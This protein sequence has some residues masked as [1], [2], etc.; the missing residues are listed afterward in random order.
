M[1]SL[2]FPVRLRICGEGALGSEAETPDLT[3]DRR[4]HRIWRQQLHALIDES[5][6]SPHLEVELQVNLLQWT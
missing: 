6:A 4:A 5:S 1:I 2:S 3:R